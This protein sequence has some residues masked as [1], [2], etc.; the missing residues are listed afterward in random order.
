[1]QELVTGSKTADGG[2]RNAMLRALYEVI[3]KAGRNMSEASISS[4]TG[5]INNDSN[6]A[7]GENSCINDYLLL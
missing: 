3:R 4:I 5:L 7:D 6:D 1:M 2:V